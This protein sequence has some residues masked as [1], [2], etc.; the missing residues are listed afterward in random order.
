MSIKIGING[1]GRIGRAVFRIMASRPDEFEVTLIND[2]ADASSLANLLKYDSTFGL[3]PGTVE[4]SKEGL[5]VNGRMIRLSNEK[6]PENIAW[7]KGNVSVVLESSGKFT[8]REG[9]EKHITA[10]APKVLLSAPPKGEKP[11][12]A[13]IVLGVNEAILKPSM[14]IVSNASCTSNCVIPMAKILHDRFE[15][16]SGLMITAHAYTSSQALLDKMSKDP[17]RGRAAAQNIIPTTTGA[18]D[19]IGLVI[20]ELNGKLTGIALRVPVPCGSI[21]DLTV[22]LKEP[23]SRDE[24][25]AAF[26]EAAMGQMRGILEYTEEPIVSSDIIGNTHSCIFDG[27]WTRVMDKNLVK[28]LGWYD[29]EWG[30]SS[31]TVDVL[32]RMASI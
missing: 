23:H 6:D 26:R 5:K 20:P 8:T 30:Y 32:K 14:Q 31:R 25:N 22:A 21:T 13:N 19:M 1:F 9:L 10:G 2:I 16:E 24:I 4:A 29:N 12:D 27:T 28:V 17:R 18:A 11:M 7:E 3:F 15:I